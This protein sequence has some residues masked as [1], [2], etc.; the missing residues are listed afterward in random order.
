MITIGTMK[1]KYGERAIVPVLIVGG[2]F[3]MLFALAIRQVVSNWKRA[4]TADLINQALSI[5]SECERKD[6][7]YDKKEEE[8]QKKDQRK[9]PSTKGRRDIAQKKS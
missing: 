3:G 8:K 2:L 7:A 5:G 9:K 1:S 4:E 6:R